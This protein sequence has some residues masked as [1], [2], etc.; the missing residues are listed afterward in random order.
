MA[1]TVVVAVI[2]ADPNDNESFAPPAAMPSGFRTV[3][4]I[5]VRPETK[6]VDCSGGFT[7]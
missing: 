2:R 6:N 3:P 5:V 1:V 7:G 4:V